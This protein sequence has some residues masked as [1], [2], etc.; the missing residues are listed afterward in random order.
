MKHAA[1]SNHGQ[2]HL[3]AAVLDQKAGSISSGMVIEER[4]LSCQQTRLGC[5]PAVPWNL[6]TLNSHFPFYSGFNSTS[7]TTAG[8]D[9]GIMY[10]RG[11][12]CCSLRTSYLST[13]SICWVIFIFLPFILCDFF[14]AVALLPFQLVFMYSLLIC[15]I[16][17][18]WIFHSPVSHLPQF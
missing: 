3:E 13:S 15:L 16:L 2:W 4:M 17:Y 5:Y 18:C 8:V 1:F 10:W 7:L 11:A 14:Q 9:A 6:G 12:H